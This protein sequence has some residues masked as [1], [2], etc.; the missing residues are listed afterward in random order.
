MFVEQQN[1]A[2]DE[3]YADLKGAANNDERK[4]NILDAMDNKVRSDL[5]YYFLLPEMHLIDN[6]INDIESAAQH[7]AG[8]STDEEALK[9]RLKIVQSALGRLELTDPQSWAEIKQGLLSNSD[10]SLPKIL[11]FGQRRQGGPNG[12]ES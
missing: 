12:I 11:R 8:L 5:S 4:I 2:L 3:R 1:K 9:E 7:D 6:L 10:M